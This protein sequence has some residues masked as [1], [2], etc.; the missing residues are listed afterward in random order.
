MDGFVIIA[1]K[2]RAVETYN[3]IDF[4]A[5]QTLLPKRLIF[6]GTE[7]SDVENLDQHPEFEK[8]NG[9]VLISDKPGLPI[10]RNVGLDALMA[11]VSRDEPWFVAFFDDDYRPAE[12]WMEAVRKIFVADDNIVGVTGQVI[13]DGIHGPGIT[14]EDALAYLAGDL[15]PG[16][17]WAQGDEPRDTDSAYG[18]NMAFRDNVSTDLRFDEALPLYAWQED[19]DYTG[20]AFAYGRV[21]Y[22]PAPLGVHLGVK[23][24]RN[25]GKKMG[26]SQIANPIYMRKK[27]TM[28]RMVCLRFLFRALAA[29][30]VKSFRPNMVF[31]YKG[32]FVG[33]MIALRDMLT[34]RLKPLRIL[35]L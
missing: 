7:A 2:G 25:S 30:V 17:C 9:E 15:P 14:E 23:G 27:G 22:H 8:L 24:G 10:Q 12:G 20:Q 18:C 29:N 4:L 1:T 11:H 19:R 5:R 13:A 16:K 3:L 34:G 33:N 35:E 6:V 32:R 21:I 31:D 28:T 26:Y